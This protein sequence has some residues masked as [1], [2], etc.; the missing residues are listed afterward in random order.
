MNREAFAAWVAE[1]F[2]IRLDGSVPEEQLQA[3]VSMSYDLTATG[4]KR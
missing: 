2:G 1:H 4:K 3:L